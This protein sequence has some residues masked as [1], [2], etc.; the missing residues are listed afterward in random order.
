M[1]QIVLFDSPL[2]K[3]LEEKAAKLCL[4]P[5][6]LSRETKVVEAHLTMMEKDDGKDDGKSYGKN[7]LDDY[8]IGVSYLGTLL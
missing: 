2:K 5:S 1:Y 4:L 3:T 7:Y 6:S 8:N